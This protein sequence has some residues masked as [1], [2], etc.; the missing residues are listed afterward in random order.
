MLNKWVWT[1]CYRWFI[2]KTSFNHSRKP[3]WNGVAATQTAV[4]ALTAGTAQ[5]SV[6]AAEKTLV[7]ALT[8]SQTDGI[9]A[10]MI[11]NSSNST[12]TAGVGSRVRSL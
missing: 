6:G 11:Y 7:A 8:A 12:L 1:T 3:V 5:T 4:A 2:C 9:I 10:K